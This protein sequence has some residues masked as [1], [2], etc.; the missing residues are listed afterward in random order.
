MKPLFNEEDFLKAKS[1]E[2]FLCQCYHCNSE[3]LTLKK[4]IKYELEHKRGR[5]KFCSVK[6]HSLFNHPIVPKVI[7]NCKNCNKEF[8][9][10]SS[11]IKITKNDFCSRSCA[12]IHNNKGRVQSE[13]TK[14]KISKALF[15]GLPKK[16]DRIKENYKPREAGAIRILI[17]KCENCDKEFEHNSNKSRRFCTQS[18]ST[19]NMIKNQMAIDP[20]F[21]IKQGRRSADAQSISRRSKNE[22]C[23]GELCKNKFHNVLFN[24]TMFNGWDA[25]VIIEDLKLAVLWNGKWHYEKITKKHSVE[26]VQNRDKIKINEI[27]KLGYKSYVIKDMGK[28]KPKFVQEKFD[29]MLVYLK[30]I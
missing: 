10:K 7:V 3:F 15:K 11:Q 13:E 23:F 8:G 1:E 18:C 21:Y 2:K 9:K 28:Y 27:E 17:T 20:E 4:L 16:R 19:K 22:I 30:L 26:Q 24:E 25:D 29:E 12:G 14:A 5:V 6:C